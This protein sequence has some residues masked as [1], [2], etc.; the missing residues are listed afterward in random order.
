M[1]NLYQLFVNLDC[2]IVEI[3]PLVVTK[4]DEIIALDAKIKEYAFGRRKPGLS[5]A[6]SRMGRL[7]RSIQGNG[8]ICSSHGFSPSS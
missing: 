4:D 7:S 2:S 3:N 6:S 5:P 8:A 1:K